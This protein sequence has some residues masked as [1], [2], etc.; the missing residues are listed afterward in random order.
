[1]RTI[2]RTWGNSL[3]VRLPR[4]IAEEVGITV[5]SPVEISV[6]EGSVVLSPIEGRKKRLT[7]LVSLMTADSLHAPD[8][9]G[10][11]VGRESL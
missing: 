5:D 8:D 7:K 2:V 4:I 6:L 9:F 1:V 11:P 3:A 10:D